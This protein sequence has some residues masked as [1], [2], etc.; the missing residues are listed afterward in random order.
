MTRFKKKG[1][2]NPMKKTIEFDGKFMECHF[3][4]NTGPWLVCLPGLGC[5]HD[6]F[7]P[8]RADLAKNFRLIEINH[9]GVGESRLAKDCEFSIQDL[10]DDVLGVLKELSINE[11]SLLGISMGGFISQ[12][13]LSRKVEGL[14]SVSLLCTTGGGEKYF[15]FPFIKDEDIKK[16]FAIEKETRAQ[17]SV[18][19]TTH[20]DLATVSPEVFEEIF[21]YR[22]NLSVPME[23]VI[24]QNHAA[25]NFMK[26]GVSLGETNL[27]VFVGHGE[28]DR[29]VPLANAKKLADEIKA[30]S[31]ITYPKS[32]HFFFWEKGQALSHDLNAFFAEYAK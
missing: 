13:I 31:F 24:K 15:T 20:P 21:D 14:K 25:I 3:H 4:G 11:F 26:T 6:L 1:T 8:L 12:E 10:A 7:T 28:N 27:P 9:R 2:P 29:F 5:D 16:L 23:T 18:A 22:K 32:D 19:T 17:L 30:T